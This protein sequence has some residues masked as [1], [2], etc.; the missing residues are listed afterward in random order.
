MILDSIYVSIYPY[1]STFTAGI[2]LKFI[3][4]CLMRNIPNQGVSCACEH[5]ENSTIF[6]DI[7]EAVCMHQHSVGIGLG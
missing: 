2:F 3:L 5:A 4:L 7:T 6:G 1:L